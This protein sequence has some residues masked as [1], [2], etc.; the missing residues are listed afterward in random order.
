MKEKWEMMALPLN[1][2][3]ILGK[4]L[5]F[6]SLLIYKLGVNTFLTNLRRLL[7]RAHEIMDLEGT[8]MMEP[9]MFISLFPLILLAW[10]SS[11]GGSES[12]IED[13]LHFS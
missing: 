7:G 11:P 13:C 10:A 8:M 3:V 1:H 2:W 5:S 4:S 9:Q 6:L 12:L